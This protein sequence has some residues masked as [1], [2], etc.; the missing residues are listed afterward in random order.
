[1]HG[2]CQRGQVAIYPALTAL[3]GKITQV[4]RRAKSTRNNQRVQIAGDR[5]G[6]WTNF[7]SRNAR[8]FDQDI[9]RLRHRFARQM[10]NHI[11]LLFIRRKADGLRAAA[12]NR[13]K[14]QNGFMNLG[15]VVYA[16]S[17]EHYANFFHRD[18]PFRNLL[19]R[20]NNSD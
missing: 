6:E 15:A 10:I 18:D 5:L 9:S 17:T 4:F 7:T 2:D 20:I 16:T 14:G 12:G 13:Q 1:M 3:A 11:S 8:G 19:K